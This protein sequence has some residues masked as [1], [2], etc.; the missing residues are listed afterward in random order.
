MDT[1]GDGTPHNA[2][3]AGDR[4]GPRER[5]LPGEEGGPV[6]GRSRPHR[7]EKS[8]HGSRTKAELRLGVNVGIGAIP[9]GQRDGLGGM[10]RRGRADVEGATKE[11][12][13]REARGLETVKDTA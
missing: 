2:L 7:S 11:A 1:D 8:R 4:G 5:H 12:P 9:C 10:H 6:I 13:V 3:L